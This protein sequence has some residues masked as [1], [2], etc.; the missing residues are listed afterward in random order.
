[1]GEEATLD[2][3]AGRHSKREQAL[4][5]YRHRPTDRT[6]RAEGVPPSDTAS[7]NQT[8]AHAHNPLEMKWMLQK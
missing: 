8:V 3:R 4:D 5:F 7:H 1:M 2:E 6:S